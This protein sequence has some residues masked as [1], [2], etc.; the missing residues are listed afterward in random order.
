MNRKYILIGLLV[1]ITG[2]FSGCHSWLDVQPE[3]Q[4][5]DGQLFSTESGFRTALNGIYVELSNNALYGGELSVDAVE[6]LAQRYDFSGNT[7]NAYR[8]G[9]YNYTI[10]YAKSKFAAVW[11]KAYSLIANCNKLLEYAEKNEEVLTGKMRKMIIGEAMALRA[12]LHFD[13]LRLFGPSYKA[14]PG[15][16]AIPYITK[17]SNKVSPQK[18]VSEVIDSVIVDLKAAVTDLEGR[19]PI[20]DPLYQ[21]TTGSDMYMWT[22]P[23]PDRNEFLSYRGFRLNYYAVNALLARVYAYKLDKKQAY[24]YA[25]IV[26]ESG[27]FKFTDYWKITSDIQY[28]NRILRPEIVFG[29]NVPRMTKVFEPYSPSYSSSKKWLTIKNSEQMFEGSA[30]DYR[31]NYL[32]EH[33]ILAAFDRPSCIKFVKPENADEM[34]EEE[35]GRIAPMI[36][37]SEMYYYVCEYLMDSDLNGAKTELQKLRNARNAK[38][39]LIANSPA[40]L[41]DVI[42]NDARREFMCEGQLFYFYKRLGRKVVDESGNYTMTEKDFVL[43]LPDVE[44]EFGNRLSELYK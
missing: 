13:M 11:E 14:D 9:T 19:D 16:T 4:V 43:P 32:M 31:L 42:V 5:T 36:R 2:I 27:V 25:K 38:E 15:Y 28:R 22:Q 23:M 44:L 30:N 10:D 1:C 12:F 39:A 34:T 8:L 40:E 21:A 37:I 6:I 29:F 3:D 18:T 41:E 24:D 7:T 17:Y 20:F 26:L 33:E 35:M